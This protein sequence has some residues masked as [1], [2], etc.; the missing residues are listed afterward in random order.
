MARPHGDRRAGRRRGEGG[1][2][3]Q[4]GQKVGLGWARALP[5]ESWGSAEPTVPNPGGGARR[6]PGRRGAGRCFGREPGLSAAGGQACVV[7][8]AMALLHPFLLS[9]RS[10]QFRVMGGAR[11][12]PERGL[13]GPHPGRRA[14]PRGQGPPA[15][16]GGSGKAGKRKEQEG[17][18]GDPRCLRQHPQRRMGKRGR[19][20]SWVLLGSGVRL[21]MSWMDPP[22]I[23]HPA[24][25]PPHPAASMASVPR[26]QWGGDTTG[27]CPCR[28][29]DP[30]A[31]AWPGHFFCITMWDGFS[32]IFP[33]PLRGA[34]L[35]GRDF[36]GSPLPR[37]ARCRESWAARHSL[38]EQRW[39]RLHVTG[40][41]VLM[42]AKQKVHLPG[43]RWFR[44]K[45][46]IQE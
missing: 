36:P 19:A 27:D 13:Q 44:L 25:S 15:P 26:S 29:G 41:L 31:A 4:S 37:F 11:G 5:G 7:L 24:V 17:V 22:R 8:R 14:A 30:W 34:S 9:Q 46:F 43:L 10:G 2:G 12:S 28:P 21:C 32:W 18:S 23:L 16:P 1:G 38:G 3:R 6:L 45:K 20:S 40:K 33:S 39:E 42:S 35:A